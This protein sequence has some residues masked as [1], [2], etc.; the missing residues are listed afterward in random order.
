MPARIEIT[1]DMRR[2]IVEGRRAEPPRT[3][4]S[5]SEALGVKSVRTAINMAI[6]AKIYTPT[7]RRR[8][9]LDGRAA[10]EAAWARMRHQMP[11]QP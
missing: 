8:D 2:V 7:Y 10:F 1:P 11:A 4:K 9:A 5:I 6:R 3:W